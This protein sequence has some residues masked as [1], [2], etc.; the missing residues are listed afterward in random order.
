MTEAD[1]LA[2]LDP[3]LM[4]AWLQDANPLPGPVPRQ[5]S[6]RKLRL[7]A[8]ACR[9]SFFHGHLIR[10]GGWSGWESDAHMKARL[11]DDG[12]PAFTAA[13]CWA[14]ELAVGEHPRRAAFLRD[15]AGNPFR[16]VFVP[17]RCRECGIP[18]GPPAPGYYCVKCGADEARCPWRTPTVLSLAAAAYQEQAQDGSLDPARLAILADA[19]EEE[20]CQEETLLRHLRGICETCEGVGAFRSAG[21]GA[22]PCR[23]CNGSG[24]CG[25]HVRGCWS[26]DCV[27]GRS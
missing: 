1:W 6:D 16:L 20:G 9:H 4:L 2:S 3:V 21:A 25:P 23:A 5:L 27:L 22:V 14:A 24:A 18:C 10:S 13:R 15:V 12:L 17:W 19:L 7:F 8:D 11:R 26:L